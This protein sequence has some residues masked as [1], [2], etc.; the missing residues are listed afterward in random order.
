MDI[1]FEAKV[2]KIL[3][4]HRFNGKNGELVKYEFI[5]ETNEQ[6]PRQIA[7]S[8]FGEDKHQKFGI[9]L[10][11]TY[12]FFVDLASREWNG[13]W[14][15]SVSLWKVESNS[16]EQN[17]PTSG[18][19]PMEVKLNDVKRQVEDAQQ[20]AAPSSFKPH[21]QSSPAQDAEDDLPF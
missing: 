20:S 5:C 4:P 2:V 12:T 9:Q 21:P 8:Y 6:F 15:T 16:N 3:E 1:Q 18:N 10:G 19:Q 7:L 11:L 13:K 17:V 14:F